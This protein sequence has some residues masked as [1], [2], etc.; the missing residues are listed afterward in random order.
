[1]LLLRF[2]KWSQFVTTSDVYRKIRPKKTGA[3]AIDDDGLAESVQAEAAACKQAGTDEYYCVEYSRGRR[4][5]SCPFCLCK[6]SA[7]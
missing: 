6:G 5:N 4:F 1:M 2:G 3:A 7:L